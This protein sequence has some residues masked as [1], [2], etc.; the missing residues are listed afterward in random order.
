MKSFPPLSETVRRAETAFAA[1]DYESV[2]ELVSNQITGWRTVPELTN[3]AI[4]GSAELDLLA[5]RVGEA[6]AREA[7]GAVAFNV[8]SPDAE[9]PRDVY[10][11]TR[12]ETGGHVRVAGDFIEAASDRESFVVLTA[13]PNQQIPPRFPQ[14][15]ATPLERI[16]C[17]P[18]LDWLA[19]T[20]SLRA[21]LK[22]L[23]PDRVFLFNHHA[24]AS[25][26]A[27]AT[28]SVARRTYYVHCG[29]FQPA[30]GV[31]LPHV[32]HL[33]L[34]P[35]AC[36]FCRA[37]LAIDATYVPLVA[38][39]LGR[40]PLVQTNRAPVLATCGS[41][42]KYDLSYRLPYDQIIA[43]L[44]SRTDATHYHLGYLHP[45]QLSQ[46][47][48]TLQQANVA[49]ERWINIVS[50]PSVWRALDELN[51]D[52]YINSFPQR[53]ARVAV[54][55]MGSGTPAVWH[56]TGPHHHAAD[57]HLAYPEAHS[58]STLDELVGIVRGLHPEWIREQGVAARAQ[59][60]RVHHPTRLARAIAA[61]FNG[62]TDDLPRTDRLFA[63]EFQHL[64][65][66]WHR[67]SEIADAQRRKTEQL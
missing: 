15:A 44:L 29:D 25:I 8:P 59:Y 63:F 9:R 30:L 53:G 65:R 38:P 47:K 10:L 20:R 24:D 7:P 17:L 36:T 21:L 39:D 33:D 12:T 5:N 26:I 28:P 55:V 4:W 46:I 41:P 18:E 58:W 49:P 3:N 11:F 31:F 34:T 50:V 43:G 14:L 48:A 13:Q 23:Q 64:Q 2:L 62:V 19:R 35:R 1:G 60:D 67:L 40:R 16:I 32:T 51:V 42:S 22:H 57:L 6:L 45:P 27:A 52:L 56:L 54:E 61:D 66:S 37:V